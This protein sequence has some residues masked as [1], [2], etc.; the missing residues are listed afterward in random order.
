MFIY[1]KNNKTIDIYDIYNLE[2]ISRRSKFGYSFVDF[3]F[4]K[5]MEL[6]L[7]MVKIED[8]EKKNGS[9]KE[10]N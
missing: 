8:E 10:Q 7:I 3:Y 9:I 4:S 5:G 1:N 2:V 6:A